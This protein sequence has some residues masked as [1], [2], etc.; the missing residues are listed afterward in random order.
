MI[1]FVKNIIVKNIIVKNIINMSFHDDDFYNITHNNINYSDDIRQLFI[2]IETEDEDQFL[3]C[4]IYIPRF[5]IEIYN[6]I[7]IET[8]LDT[9]NDIWYRWQ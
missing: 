8:I 9:Q 5:I 6:S 1:F 4:L 2:A 7:I 3:R